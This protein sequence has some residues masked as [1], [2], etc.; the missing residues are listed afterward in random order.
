MAVTIEGSITN[1]TANGFTH[2]TTAATEALYVLV[3]NLY[4]PGDIA[5]VKWN[6]TAMTKVVTTTEIQFRTAAGIWRLLSPDVGTYNV[7]WDAES[8]AQAC[9]AINLSGLDTGT[10]E[11]DSDVTEPTAGATSSSLTITSET[12]G[13]VIDIACYL[14]T[15]N[16]DSLTMTGDGTQRYN[17]GLGAS[18][19]GDVGVATASGATSVTRGWSVTNGDY[20]SHCALAINPAATGTAP[21]MFSLLGVG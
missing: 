18:P 4:N 2:T 3:G 1:S 5:N 17:V 20:W 14:D 8:R 19:Y 16:N 9:S 11:G 10:P 21:S 6:G 13:L 7:T 15:S 12:G